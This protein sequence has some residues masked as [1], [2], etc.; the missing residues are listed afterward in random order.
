MIDTVD[1]YR[2]ELSLT[3][4]LSLSDT[5]L[6]VREGLLLRVELEEGAI[7]WGDAA[8]L[9]GF[10]TETL[11]TAVDAGRQLA[12]DLT[13]LEGSDGPPLDVVARDLVETPPLPPSVR[14]AAES[15]LLEARAK[16]SGLSPTDVLRENYPDVSLNALLA[17]DTPDL[18][19]RARELR[20]NG[21]RAVKLKVGRR[22]LDGDIERVRTVR[23]AL[24]EDAALRLDANRAWSFEEAVTFAD[25]LR[26]D[27][28]AYVEEP[29]SEPE[30]IP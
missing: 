6:A 4:S 30:R 14:F 7:G 9:P 16:V 5:T 25:Q 29:L 15:A 1:L 2:Y 13:G 12:S 19:A 18:A 8:P 26:D 21:Y 20:R 28:V 3:N 27:A 22:S 17:A 10:S 23:D 11:D 24:G